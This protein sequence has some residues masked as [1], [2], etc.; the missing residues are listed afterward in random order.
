[1]QPTSPR[2]ECRPARSGGGGDSVQNGRASRA[3]IESELD[4]A[5]KQLMKAKEHVLALETANEILRAQVAEGRGH[6]L[7]RTPPHH[8]HCS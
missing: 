4:V 7:R 2:A 8:C 5:R 1:M 3:E 6:G